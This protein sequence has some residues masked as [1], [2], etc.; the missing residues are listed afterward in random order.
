MSNSDPNIPDGSPFANNFWNRFVPTSRKYDCCASRVLQLRCQSRWN[1]LRFFGILRLVLSPG[2]EGFG[3]ARAR[4]RARSVMEVRAGSDM[5]ADE[6]AAAGVV[7]VV[8]VVVAMSDETE[9]GA[10]SVPGVGL[11]TILLRK[12]PVVVSAM[13][14]AMLL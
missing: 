13:F 11:L 10:A 3:L 2:P 4:A 8:V 5:A 6:M 9:A 12:R 7:V 14:D 1:S